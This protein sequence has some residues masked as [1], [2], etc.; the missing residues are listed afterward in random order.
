[1]FKKILLVLLILAMPIFVYAV[2]LKF[3][4]LPNEGDGTEGYKVLYGYSSRNYVE[5]SEVGF[6]NPV[7]GRIVH[8]VTGTNEDITYFFAVIA[9]VGDEG[10]LEG[11]RKYVE[12][13]YSQEIEYYV[14]VFTMIAPEDFSVVSDTATFS[15]LPNTQQ[16]LTGY[17]IYC[18]TT[19][20][21]QIPE[22]EGHDLWKP[23]SLDSIENGKVVYTWPDFP[24]GVHY[25]VT[26]SL[27][28]NGS[29]RI[30]SIFSTETI[31]NTSRID[32]PQNFM[33]VP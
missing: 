7:D 21:A 20:A 32:T 5:T 24:T 11:E 2:D 9:Y 33:L 31:I 19:P 8:T 6:P 12:S 10:V 27:G 23:V 25:C 29:G 26:V 30:S 15:W 16:E 17:E 14:P 28:D 4:W 1:M 13:D 18:D 22:G 3:S